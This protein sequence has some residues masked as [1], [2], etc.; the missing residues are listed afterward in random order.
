MSGISALQDLQ[1]L[2]ISVCDSLGSVGSLHSLTSLVAEF[3]ESAVELDLQNPKLQLLDLRADIV[4]KVRDQVCAFFAHMYM[5]SPALQDGHHCCP[6]QQ[7]FI[8]VIPEYA[9][10]LQDVGMW[11]C[12]SALSSLR[13]LRLC[14]LRLADLPAEVVLL[15]KLTSLRIK[16]GLD[17]MSRD[18][19][20]LE[21]LVELHL[22]CKYFSSLPPMLST[23]RSLEQLVLTESSMEISIEGVNALK[24]LPRL[25]QVT[26]DR[27][28]LG[29]RSVLKSSQEIC[30]W[31]ERCHP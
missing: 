3:N 30:A 21:N 22:S 23:C 6:S 2:D 28:H 10:R 11:R 19:S 29:N 31:L 12:L 8:L 1:Q 16:H 9:V 18:L 5:R 24:C 4:Y 20:L 26:M 7:H 14:N 25:H 17:S 13:S 15:T 27:D